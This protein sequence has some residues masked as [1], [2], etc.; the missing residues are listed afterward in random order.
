M[1][2]ADEKASALASAKEEV[3]DGLGAAVTERAVKK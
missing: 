2:A 1:P 3:T